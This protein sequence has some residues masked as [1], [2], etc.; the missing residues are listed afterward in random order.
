[1]SNLF[2]F[3][4]LFLFFIKCNDVNPFQNETSNSPK[5]EVQC[6]KGFYPNDGSCFSCYENCL[7]CDGIKCTECKEGYFPSQM[8]CNKC[9][10]NCLK[11][12]GIKCNQCLEG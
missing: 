4:L 7:E 3:N 8:N 11:C 6:N 12:D 9:Y 5:I 2:F 1:M 10:P